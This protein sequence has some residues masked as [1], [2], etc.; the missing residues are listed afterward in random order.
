MSQLPSS[1]AAVSQMHLHPSLLHRG[2]P[3]SFVPTA[4]IVDSPLHLDAHSYTEYELRTLPM[5]FSAPSHSFLSATNG[6]PKMKRR[7]GCA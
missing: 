2:A 6:H 3:K 4:K 1:V 7:Y 5:K